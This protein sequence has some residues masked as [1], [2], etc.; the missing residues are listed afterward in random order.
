MASLNVNTHTSIYTIWQ[1]FNVTAGRDIRFYGKL[2]LTGCDR[3]AQFIQAQ[4][5][6]RPLNTLAHTH[7]HLYKLG[8]P[9]SVT[10]DLGKNITTK[11]ARLSKYTSIHEVAAE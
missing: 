10:K 9:P 6:L 4:A 2:Q 11:I 5:R 8:S 3:T 7:L 1:A